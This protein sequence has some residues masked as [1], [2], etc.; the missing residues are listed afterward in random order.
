MTMLKLITSDMIDELIEQAGVAIRQRTN[1]N[2]H[3]SLSDPVQRLFVVSR[4]RAYFRPHRH[5]AK[6]EFALVIKGLFD[7]LVFD[8]GGRVIERI[9]VGP[10]ADVI[11]FEIP[12]NIWHSWVTMTDGSVFFE[13]KNGPYDPRISE[14]A[15]WSPE[16][17]VP[18]VDDFVLR[19]RNAKVGDSVGF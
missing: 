14:F 11:G 8:D 7:V 10:D 9:S 3:E 18:G 13:T 12:V 1:H 6:W 17:G 15:H 5:S 19:M 2:V 4:L 16:E